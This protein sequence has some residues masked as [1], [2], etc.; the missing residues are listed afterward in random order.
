MKDLPPKLIVILFC[1]KL[2]FTSIFQT[3][4]MVFS[5]PSHVSKHKA[6]AQAKFGRKKARTRRTGL[7]PLVDEFMVIVCG[8]QLI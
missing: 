4:I 5:T 3:K 6:A 1:G 8:F 7:T 2:L